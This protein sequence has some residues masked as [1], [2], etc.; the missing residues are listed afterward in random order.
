MT[1]DGKAFGQ[2]IVGVVKDYVAKELGPLF[3]R[4]SAMEKRISELPAPKDGKDADP[5]AV[6]AIVAEGLKEE[7]SDIRAAVDAIEVPA[8][9]DVTALIEEALAALPKPQDGKSVT[10][11]DVRPLIQEAVTKAVAAIPVPKDGKD[12]RDGCDAVDAMIDKDGN[13]IITFSD[14]RLKNV[15]LV[16]GKDGAPGLDGRDGLDGVGFDDMDLE[17]RDTGVYLVWT[18]GEVIKE[19]RLPVP[20]DMG[21]FKDG[22]TYQRGDGVTWGGQYWI[23]S[24]EAAVKPDTSKAGKPWRLAVRRGRDGKDAKPAGKGE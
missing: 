18:K 10:V 15:G 11:D 19:A 1:F 21:V 17:V 13:L 20:M 6:A 7:L 3:E 14:G 22:Q 16:C 23:A 4:M 5:E 9:P 2:E 8:L 12:G 24:E